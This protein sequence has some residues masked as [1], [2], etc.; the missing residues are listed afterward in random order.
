[1]ETARAVR[2]EWR[3]GMSLT[4]YAAR[5]VD[6]MPHLG[7]L[8]RYA[9]EAETVVEFGVRGGVST[10]AMLRGFHEGWAGRVFAVDNDPDVL[11]MMPPWVRDDPR[12]VLIIGNDLEVDLPKHADL[13][14]IDSGHEYEQTL[15]ELELAASLDPR[16][17]LL[18]DYL[19]DETPGVRQAVDEFTSRRVWRLVTVHPS[20][21][22]L[23][24]LER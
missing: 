16:S 17:I 2:I 23:A 14:M 11:E 13:V 1:M 7:A 19:Y 22:G 24:V 15:A 5:W 10:W 3:P 9:S 6:M 8:T 21:W 20:H 12:L 18:H 4:E